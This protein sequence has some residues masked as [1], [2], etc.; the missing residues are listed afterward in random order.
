[1]CDDSSIR[2]CCILTSGH[3]KSHNLL[4]P[5]FTP[6]KIT[7][8]KIRSVLARTGVDPMIQ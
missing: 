2:D 8:T 6:E 7:I 3:K 1:M 5:L 4:K